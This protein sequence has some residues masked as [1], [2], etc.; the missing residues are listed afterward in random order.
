MK[1]SNIKSE[2]HKMQYTPN[3]VCIVKHKI[4]TQ[5]IYSQNNTINL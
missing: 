1:G 2:I 5:H 4:R 3:D